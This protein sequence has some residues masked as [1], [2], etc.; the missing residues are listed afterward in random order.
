MNYNGKILKIDLSDGKIT[1]LKEK[2][3]DI[4]N[5]IGGK[6]LA[7]KLLSDDL[8][9][10]DP[11]SSKNEI[12]FSAGP[13]VGDKDISNEGRF[14]IAT[15]GIN[16][17]KGVSSVGGLFGIALKLVGYDAMIVTGQARNNS[18]LLVKNDRCEIVDASEF[19]GLMTSEC[20]EFYDTRS[21][22]ACIGPAGEN[23]LSFAS[24]VFDKHILA[25]KNGI[26]AVMGW[27]NLKAIILNSNQKIDDP[28]TTCPVKCGKYNFFTNAP[29]WE[30]AG[31][32]FIEDCGITEKEEV[33]DLV[34]L[35][36]DLG[37]DS[38]SAGKV[39]RCNLGSRSSLVNDVKVFLEEISHGKKFENCKEDKKQKRIDD[40]IKTILDSFGMCA[41]AYKNLKIED[42]V[43]IINAKTKRQFTKESILEM[44]N[45]INQLAND[46]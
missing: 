45:K 29:H 11:F 32:S 1:E 18:Y 25:S 41:F 7:L 28:C 19:S 37:I 9:S 3:T 38:V 17:E 46:Q 43:G 35:C 31:R 40:P 14:S 16:G 8:K 5:F 2:D 39:P 44:A 34:D 15:F 24:V 13:F 20:D 30:E 6:G 42:L 12:V 27:K 36:D 10:A 4:M 23:L 22:V 33:Q 21:S 26:G